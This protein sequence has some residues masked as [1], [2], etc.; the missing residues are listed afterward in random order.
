MRLLLA[1]ANEHKLAEFADLLA[2][3]AVERLPPGMDLGPEVGETFAANALGKARTAAGSTGRPAVADDSGIEAEALGGRPGVYSRRYAGENASD[4]ENLAKLL[5]QAPAGSALAYVCAIA[6]VDPETGEE[7]LFEGRCTGRL[8][9]EPRGTGGFG[10]DPAFLPDDG[11]PGLTMAE[12]SAAAKHAISH[13]GRAAR[14][15]LDW[16]DGEGSG[17]RGG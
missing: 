15:L 17:A 13:R 9:A 10:Y 1:S 16:L 14:A 2:P 8:A 6:Y 3:H 12:L 5:A 4:E 11:P 7:R